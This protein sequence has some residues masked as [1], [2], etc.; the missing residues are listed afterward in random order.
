MFTSQQKRKLSNATK[1]RKQSEAVPDD[2]CIQTETL[3]QKKEIRRKS[4]VAPLI[5]IMTVSFY[6]CWTPY[7]TIV[8]LQMVGVN[9]PIFPSAL[10]FLFAKLGVVINPIIYIFYNKE[11][12]LYLW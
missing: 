9:A 6:M 4:T 3:T 12:V 11:V 5:G 10:A 8:I 2:L 7:A 1:Q